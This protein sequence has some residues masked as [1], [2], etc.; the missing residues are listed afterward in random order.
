MGWYVIV[1]TENNYYLLFPVATDYL[2]FK[3]NHLITKHT[4]F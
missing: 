2:E 4:T 1:S 3:C